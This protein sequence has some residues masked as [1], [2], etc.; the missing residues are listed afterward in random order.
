MWF[1]IGKQLLKYKNENVVKSFIYIICFVLSLFAWNGF[2]YKEESRSI[3]EHYENGKLGRDI[4]VQELRRSEDFRSDGTRYD[5]TSELRTSFTSNRN[6]KV[7]SKEFSFKERHSRKLNVSS[8]VQ[9]QPRISKYISYKE[10]TYSST[11]VRLGIK[12][13]PNENQLKNMQNL[14]TLYFDRLREH[15]KKPIYISSFYRS[16]ALN[17]RVKGAI[18]SDHM[19]NDNDA[20][21]DI[22]MDGR[23]I[24]SNNKIFY[25]TRD[26]LPFYKLI[27]EFPV[28]GKL[29]WVHVSISR[30]ALKNKQKNILIP[31]FK[32]TRKVYL[33]YKGNEYLVK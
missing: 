1:L 4:L 26:S 33:P 17:E 12:N 2:I 20:G 30:D 11:A 32:G 28:K 18:Y 7:A 27:A 15:F 16:A 14:G 8:R 10:A 13:D 5:R 9:P 19:A 25:Y 31:T 23:G 29:S 6:S 24:P 3:S 21:I 22:D